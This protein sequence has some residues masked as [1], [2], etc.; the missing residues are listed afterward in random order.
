MIHLK[1]SPEIKFKS[2]PPRTLSWGVLNRSALLFWACI[3]LYIMSDSVFVWAISNFSLFVFKVDKNDFTSFKVRRD[4]QYEMEMN[5]WHQESHSKYECVNFSTSLS[6]DR[7]W[8]YPP[9]WAPSLS[10]VCD[11][12]LSQWQRK[13]FPFTAERPENDSQRK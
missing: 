2:F 4:T 13:D 12:S 6:D 8:T 9:K 3:A 11:S 1:N 7:F 5:T 10:A